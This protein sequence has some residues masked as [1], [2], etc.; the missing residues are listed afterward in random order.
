MRPVRGDRVRHVGV[1]AFPGEDG[2]PAAVLQSRLAVLAGKPEDPETA[3]E[4]LG[5]IVELPGDP[6]Y[7]DPCLGAYLRGFLKEVRRVPVLVFPGMSEGTTT[8]LLGV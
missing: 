5:G 2:V 6:V 1:V 7:E 8:Q 4:G 3:P